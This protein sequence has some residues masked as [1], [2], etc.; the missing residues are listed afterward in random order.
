[1]VFKRLLYFFFLKFQCY[2]IIRIGHKASCLKYN[3]AIWK[4]CKI[5]CNHHF[6]ASSLEQIKM[7]ENRLDFDWKIFTPMVMFTDFSHIHFVILIWSSKYSSWV[8][9][10]RFFRLMKHMLRLFFWILIRFRNVDFTWMLTL[11]S[12]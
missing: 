8:Y 12:G 3:Y 7:T 5:K 4:R 11:F 6:E 1:M 10:V 9:Y 2:L